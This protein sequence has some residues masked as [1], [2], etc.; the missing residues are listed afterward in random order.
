MNGGVTL[1][2]GAEVLGAVTNVNGKIELTGA[3][4]AGGL[5]P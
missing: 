4:V 5:E 3:H 1:R 2:T